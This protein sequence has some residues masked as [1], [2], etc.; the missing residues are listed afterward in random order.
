MLFFWARRIFSR[1]FLACHGP[2]CRGFGPTWRGPLAGSARV[3]PPLSSD[4]RVAV[5]LHGRDQLLGGGAVAAVAGCSG[6]Q[7]CKSLAPLRLPGPCRPPG[8]GRASP[9]HQQPRK[10]SVFGAAASWGRG[11]GPHRCR[12]AG[13]CNIGACVPACRSVVR[14]R[15]TA[16][17]S[18]G[19]QGL[20]GWPPVLLRRCQWLRRW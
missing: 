4:Q 19:H 11:P 1:L 10:A 2:P 20:V 15:L 13:C 7:R 9:S 6:C 17:G 16:A 8:R 5:G 14:G 12:L 3:S 18:S